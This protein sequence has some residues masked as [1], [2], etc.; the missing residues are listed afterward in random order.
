MSNSNSSSDEGGWKKVDNKKKEKKQIRR[1]VHQE[2]LTPPPRV[3]RSTKSGRRVQITSF[4]T[5]HCAVRDCNNKATD[6]FSKCV[7]PTCR[8][9]YIILQLSLIHISEPTRPY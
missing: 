4:D 7:A 1:E 2:E 3:E 5:S 8:R 6:K 9:Y